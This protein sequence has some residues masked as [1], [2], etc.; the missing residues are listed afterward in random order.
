MELGLRGRVAVITGGSKGIG[1]A[2]AVGLAQEGANVVICAR[3]QR[4]LEEAASEISTHSSGRVLPV[5]GDMSKESDAFRLVETALKNYGRL[6]ILVNCAGSSPGGT[7]LNLNEEHWTE[8]LNLKFMGYV[9][10]AKASIQAVGKQGF[11]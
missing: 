5:V 9:R 2:S 10:T 4:L 3:G 6:D 7:I 11:S 8:S 1:K